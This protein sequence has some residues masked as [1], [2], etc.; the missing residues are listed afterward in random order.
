MEA[1]RKNPEIGMPGSENPDLEQ[2]I[3]HL[4]PELA[5]AWQ[6]CTW[7]IVHETGRGRPEIMAEMI[8]EFMI[9]H[10]C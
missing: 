10:G 5:R 8:R 6:R 4:P 7:L 9:K 3:L 2:V 1:D